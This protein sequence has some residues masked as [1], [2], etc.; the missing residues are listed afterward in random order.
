MKMRGRN[1]KWLGAGD[2]GAV[3]EVRVIVV[4][5]FGPGIGEYRD[6]VSTR[7]KN[8][9]RS[10]RGSVNREKQA[11]GREL[12]A[13][14]FFLDVKEACNVLNHLFVGKSHFRAGWTVG[15][16]RCDDVGGVASTVSGRG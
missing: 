11:I 15:R 2:R 14:F 9:N 4:F 5:K 1:G 7:G 16:G 10:R 3:R 8:G 6:H 13:D 12:A